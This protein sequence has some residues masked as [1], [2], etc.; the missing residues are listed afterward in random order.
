MTNGLVVPGDDD[1]GCDGDGN[2]LGE[3][4]FPRVPTV[5]FCPAQGWVSPSPPPPPAAAAFIV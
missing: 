1:V 5:E 3:Q 2:S 4:D